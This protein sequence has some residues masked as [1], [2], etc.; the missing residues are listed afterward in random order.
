MEYLQEWNELIQSHPI[1]Q[2]AKGLPVITVPLM[3]YT[4]DTSGNRSRK[5]NK[6]DNW[7]LLLAGEDVCIY[8]Q[9]YNYCDLYVGLPKKQNRDLNNIHLITC[10]NKVPCMELGE[11][12]THDLIQLEEGVV[13]YMM[14][15]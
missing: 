1:R 7:T 5:W 6:F 12:F 4:D 15:I 9:C 8:S 10:S 2:T 3:L 13:M 11:G 14:R